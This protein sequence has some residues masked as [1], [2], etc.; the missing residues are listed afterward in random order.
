LVDTEAKVT[1]E[2]TLKMEE[3]KTECINEIKRDYEEQIGK[4][5]QVRAK[6]IH[7]NN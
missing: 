7:N 4:I 1:K 5:E 6:I 2:V 3:E